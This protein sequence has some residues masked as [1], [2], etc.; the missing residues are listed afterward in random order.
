MPKNINHPLSDAE[1]QRI[2][3]NW[4]FLKEN[5]LQ[6]DIRD[7]FIDKGIWD[8]RDLEE[9]DTGKIQEEKNENFLKLLLKSGPRAYGVFIEALNNTGSKH[10]IEKLQAT[11][12]TE[13]SV[14]DRVIMIYTLLFYQRID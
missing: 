9:I 11:V 14:N 12:I 7:N 6:Q 5:L 1:T 2:K 8:L 10:I 4:K 3:R 13:E